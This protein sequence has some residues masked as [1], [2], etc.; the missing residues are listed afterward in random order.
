[1]Q[2]RNDTGP[3]YSHKSAPQIRITETVLSVG[4]TDKCYLKTSELFINN[5][6]LTWNIMC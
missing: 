6:I 3:V 2:G 4:D 5:S 1:M